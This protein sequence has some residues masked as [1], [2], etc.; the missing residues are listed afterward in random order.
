M[1][2][3]YDEYVEEAELMLYNILFWA[4]LKEVTD[5]EKASKLA[6]EI[7]DLLEAR[8]KEYSIQEILL[9][10]RINMVAVLA[11]GILQ[12]KEEGGC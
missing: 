7:A 9:A 5:A 4:Q 2:E 10:L 3:K 6:K 1:S 12:A 11:T 8:F